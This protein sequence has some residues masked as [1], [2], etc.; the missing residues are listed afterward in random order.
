[1]DKLSLDLFCWSLTGRG[2]Q[3]HGPCCGKPPLSW[4]SEVIS[5]DTAVFPAWIFSLLFIFSFLFFFLIH[6][7][8]CFFFPPFV[9]SNIKVLTLFCR[10]CGCGN[11]VL[12]ESDESHGLSPPKMLLCT[13]L[14]ILH[15][16]SVDS[17]ITC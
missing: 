12:F 13:C 5:K 3:V 4:D 6:L 10:G 7:T 8:S 15:E 16:I 11:H 14:Q 2:E 9:F 1:M 17:Q